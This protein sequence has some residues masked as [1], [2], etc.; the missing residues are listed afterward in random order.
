[1]T[2]KELITKLL[3]YNLNTEVYLTTEYSQE[4]QKEIGYTGTFHEVLD[5]EEFGD[6]VQIKFEI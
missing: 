4:K 5:V 2:V 6:Y 1:M 3:D